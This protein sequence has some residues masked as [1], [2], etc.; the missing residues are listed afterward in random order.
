MRTNRQLQ[1]EY[2]W[3]VLIS[4]YVLYFSKAGFHSVCDKSVISWAHGTETL[5]MGCVYIVSI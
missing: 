4:F 2:Y 1:Q 3:A 5:Y